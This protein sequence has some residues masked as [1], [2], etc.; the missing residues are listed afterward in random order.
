[1]IFLNVTPTGANFRARN[2]LYN[3]NC[4]DFLVKNFDARNKLRRLFFSNASLISLSSAVCLV[5]AY[6]DVIYSEVNY[7]Y[8]NND[9]EI[10]RKTTAI[11]ER[12]H[13]F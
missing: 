10:H 13:E 6:W 5:M 12:T 1:M 8:R 2:L 11:T 7:T 4:I 3:V 9:K